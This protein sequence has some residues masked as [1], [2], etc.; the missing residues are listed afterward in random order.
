MAILKYPL[1]LTGKSANNLISGEV[2]SLP[3]GVNRA[4]VA[5]YGPFYSASLVVRESVTNRLLT[6][7]TH[8]KAIQLDAEATA[9]SGL[10]VCAV[11]V[12]TDQSVAN[13]V[14]VQY[15]VVGGE[16]STSVYAL[17]QMLDALNLDN[18]SVAWGDVLGK[19]S[20][21]VPTEHRHDAGDLYGFEYLSIHS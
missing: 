1:D 5:S 8:Y 15:Q 7:N 6:A 13:R 17:Q 4:F 9:A 11:I 18:R 16:Y 10:E 20:E 2:H 3:V 12:V 14:T 19:P 21:Y